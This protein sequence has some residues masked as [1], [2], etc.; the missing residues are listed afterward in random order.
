MNPFVLARGAGS[1]PW[2]LW[3]CH[4]VHFGLGHALLDLAALAVP[5]VLVQAR[6]RLFLG[7]LLVAPLLSL[8]LLPDLGD[9]TYR[10]ASGLACAAWAMA[11]CHLLRQRRTRLEG[12]GLLALLGLK[13]LVEGVHGAGFLAG[14][15]GWVSLPAAHRWGAALGVLGSPVLGTW[16][17]GDPA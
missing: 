10:G 8:A 5:F 3:T 15:P 7:L 11:G 6:R 12:L 2:R 14:G 17:R 9:G 1:E 16:R 13:L 4:A